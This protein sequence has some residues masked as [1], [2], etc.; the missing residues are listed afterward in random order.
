[1]PLSADV[2][3]PRSQAPQFPDRCVA[4]AASHPGGT[5]TVASRTTNWLTLLTGGGRLVQVTAP[6]CPGCAARIRHQRM[7]RTVAT[8]VAIGL[9]VAAALWIFRGQPS[10]PPAA[11]LLSVIGPVVLVVLWELF[12]PPA[13]GLTVYPAAV[14]YEFRDPLYAEEFALLNGGE[15][16]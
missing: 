5:V 7:L 14:E 12:H 15:V 10:V 8:F 9:G 13:I 1:M 3:L 11:R 6:A 16:T 2:R 4:C